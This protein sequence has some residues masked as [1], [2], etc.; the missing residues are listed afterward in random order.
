MDI[1]FCFLICT[2][3]IQSQLFAQ[4]ESVPTEDDPNME[5]WN[6]LQ[7]QYE[8]IDK[9]SLSLEAQLRLKSVGETY[10]CLLLKYKRN[11]S[12]NPF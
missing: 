9:L 6:A 2:L 10:I 1:R 12:L 7:L 3:F 11:T 5:S 4:D 8:P